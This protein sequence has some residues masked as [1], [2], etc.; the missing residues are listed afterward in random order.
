MGELSNQVA[1][2]TGGR[3]GIGLALATGLAQAGARVAVAAASPDCQELERRMRTLGADWAYFQADLA[4]RA[5]QTGLIP[6]V[7]ERFGRLDILVNNAG[8][9]HR[10][11]ALEFDL[12]QW[13]RLIGVM[14]SAVFV[15]SQAAARVMAGQGGGKIV[16]LASLASFQG[17]WT[18][19]AYT[20][21]KHGVAGLTK[22]LANEWAGRNI[23]VNAIAPGYIETD[24]CAALRNDP[25]R[26]R[27]IRERIPAGRW[28]RPED[29]VGALL[30]LVSD[31]SRYVHGHV[32]AVDGGWLAR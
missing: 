20:A 26:E 11:P 25:E 8:A 17:G 21:A 18:I 24:L 30:F 6:R 27:Q 2:V 1:L 3:R 5:Q 10:Q 9:Q 22:A 19:P 12:D 4:D 32:L 29:L 7:L 28:G 13:D 16:T 14:L 15:L 31:A 23:N